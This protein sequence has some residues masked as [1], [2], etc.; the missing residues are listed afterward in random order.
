MIER[1]DE[2][3]YIALITGQCELTEEEQEKGWHF[4]PEWDYDLIHPT[5]PESEACTC[6]SSQQ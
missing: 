2:L 3:R 5:W 6:F 1:L 4:C